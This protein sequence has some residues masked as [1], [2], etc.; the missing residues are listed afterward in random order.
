MNTL[1]Q[2]NNII[3]GENK[4]LYHDKAFEILK[5]QER[6]G[7]YTLE[8]KVNGIH[9]VITKQDIDKLQ[10]FLDSLVPLP[11]VSVPAVL[12]IENSL[13]ERKMNSKAIDLLER[14][15]EAFRSLSNILFEDIKKVRENPSYV[16]QAKQVA[17]SAQTIVN[18]VK[19]QLDIVS[20]G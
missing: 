10:I 15:E 8:C 7:Q 20:K 14:N 1:E 2:L 18:L 5:F 11:G 19:L 12:D 13:P 16:P 17:N 9:T 4:Y 6:S 3:R